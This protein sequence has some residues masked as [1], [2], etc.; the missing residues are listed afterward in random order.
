MSRA[1]AMVSL[2]IAVLVFAGCGSEAAP[3]PVTA[4]T[5][6]PAAPTGAPTQT[7]PTQPPVPIPTAVPTQT[8][9]TPT[10][11]EEPAVVLPPEITPELV[12][13]A[14]AFLLAN[15]LD[16]GALGE[17]CVSTA[18]FAWRI[19]SAMEAHAAALEDVRAFL[20]TAD[21]GT[22]ASMLNENIKITQAFLA[23]RQT[24]RHF[25]VTDEWSM[26]QFR[27]VTGGRD[28]GYATDAE[29]AEFERRNTEQAAKLLQPLCAK[30]WLA[31]VR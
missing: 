7:P 29:S 12:D 23:L 14:Y 20:A 26:A 22:A 5:Q 31:G 27:E 28:N 17:A 25:A 4:P 21:A 2:S 15:D 24:V 9:P 16:E 13:L 3:L 8:S 11:T 10:P 18:N 30:V 6:A 1:L 19:Q